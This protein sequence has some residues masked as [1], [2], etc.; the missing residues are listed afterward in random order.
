MHDGADMP[1]VEV[2]AEKPSPFCTVR[3]TASPEEQQETRDRWLANV[4]R[5]RAFWDDPSRREAGK[6]AWLRYWCGGC[7]ERQVHEV[8][9]DGPIA[10]C[11]NCGN[12]VVLRP[13][14]RFGGM[15]R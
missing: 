8:C 13:D 14:G 10:K 2:I 6:I 1:E 11:P 15:D 9:S 4:L 5:Y 3:R 7:G 12:R